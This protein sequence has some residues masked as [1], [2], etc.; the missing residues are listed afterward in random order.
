MNAMKNA[1]VMA[2]ATSLLAT[3]AHAGPTVLLNDG[4]DTENGGVGAAE[5]SGFANFSAANIDLLAPGYFFNLCQAAG[6]S[7]ACLDMEGSGNGGSMQVAMA[8]K[9]PAG[10]ALNDP[11]RDPRRAGGHHARGQA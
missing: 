9:T 6:G 8:I 1:W 2:L 3:L 7:N 11:G 4:F 5:Y 10:R